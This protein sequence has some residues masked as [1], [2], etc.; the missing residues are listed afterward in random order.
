MRKGKKKGKKKPTKGSAVL[1]EEWGAVLGKQPRS[2]NPEPDGPMTLTQLRSTNQLDSPNGAS[3]VADSHLNET[4]VLPGPW[5]DST[6]I[7]IC[8]VCGYRPSVDSFV[9]E[10]VTVK[11]GEEGRFR[12]GY[13]TAVI[14]VCPRAG[15][16]C[17]VSRERVVKGRALYVRMCVY[18]ERASPL[19]TYDGGDFGLLEGEEEESSD[20]RGAT[21][22]PSIRVPELERQVSQLSLGSTGGSVK[23]RGEDVPDVAF[24]PSVVSVP[25]VA[26]VASVPSVPSV[27]SAPTI[28]SA[29]PSA[30]T[31]NDD[32]EY[33]SQEFENPS[34]RSTRSPPQ[35][36]SQS[37]YSSDSSFTLDRSQN[38][39]ELLTTAQILAKSML[40]NPH[41]AHPNPQKHLLPTLDPTMVGLLLA[42]LGFARYSQ[43]FVDAGVSGLDLCNATEEDLE[44]LG[45]G[46]RPHRIRL[47]T[48]VTH[49]RRVG[50]D[51]TKLEK[52]EEVMETAAVSG[53]VFIDPATFYKRVAGSPVGWDFSVRASVEAKWAGALILQTAWRRHVTLKKYVLQSA[54]AKRIG[55]LTAAAIVIQCSFRTRGAMKRRKGMWRVK[56]EREEQRESACL[57]QNWFRGLKARRK[58]D[59]RRQ[60][61][62][63]TRELQVSRPVGYERS[64]RAQTA[65]CELVVLHQ[66]LASSSVNNWL[67]LRFVRL[68]LARR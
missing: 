2:T 58:V 9:V 61:V 59:R 41:A 35:S 68:S 42:Y 19:A 32:D 67:S 4:L 65:R 6:H 3:Q 57:I 7:C 46:F 20:E 51:I 24:V 11:D 1:T 53:R 45:V 54:E 66:S 56:E 31:K 48:A 64:F 40:A 38:H 34:P 29:A 27:P 10:V 63:I 16:V 15:T 25:S 36:P 28:P 33:G 14:G 43:L 62:M 50:V 47:R 39:P 37:L 12:M 17:T 13:E 21:P 30:P 26:S 18:D 8:V 44:C 23:S 52:Y 22:P 55:E 49:V 5:S 60:N